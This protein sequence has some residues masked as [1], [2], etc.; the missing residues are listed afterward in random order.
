MGVRCVSENKPRLQAMFSFPLSYF[1]V[2]FQV[3]M[4][5]VTFLIYPVSGVCFFCVSTAVPW[6]APGS[7]EYA[8][9]LI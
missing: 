2:M 5:C 7:L 3:D 1:T 8:K 6:G 4:A 9:E